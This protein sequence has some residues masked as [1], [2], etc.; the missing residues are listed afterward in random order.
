M[1]PVVE[2]NAPTTSEMPPAGFE[3][4]QESSDWL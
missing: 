3:D 2:S 1:K 4:H